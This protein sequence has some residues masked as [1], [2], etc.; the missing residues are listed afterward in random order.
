M[1]VHYSGAGQ[2][3]RYACLT[4]RQDADIP[5]CQSLSGRVLDELVTEKTVDEMINKVTRFHSVMDENIRNRTRELEEL[6][7]GFAAIETRLSRFNVKNRHRHP[8][9]E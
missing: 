5:R 8:P 3:L 9:Q 2:R 1:G 7:N 4:G 6:E